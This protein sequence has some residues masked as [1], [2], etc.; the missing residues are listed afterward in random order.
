MGFGINDGTENY[1][2]TAI[3]KDLLGPY[4]PL[5]APWHRK[6]FEG[7]VDRRFVGFSASEHNILHTVLGQLRIAGC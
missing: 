2:A 7:N 1:N 6:G 5:K 3:S 4:S